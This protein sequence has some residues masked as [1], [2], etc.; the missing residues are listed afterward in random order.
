M[1]IQYALTLSLCAAT[2][3]AAACVP[4]MAQEA[5]EGEPPF[6]PSEDEQTVVEIIRKQGIEPAAIVIIDPEGNHEIF[7]LKEYP[8]NFADSVDVSD[9]NVPSLTFQPL[10]SGVICSRYGCGTLR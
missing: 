7:Q 5:N 6:L 8:L 2:A 1:K 9:L 3:L 4:G 10:G